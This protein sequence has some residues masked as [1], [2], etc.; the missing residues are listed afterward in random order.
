MRIFPHQDTPPI[1]WTIAGSDPCGGAGL[2]ADIKTL[3]ILGAHACAIVSALTAQ[4]SVGV[5]GTETVSAAML[6]AQIEALRSDMP[7]RAIKIGMLGDAESIR[8]LAHCLAPLDVYTICDPVLVSSSGTPLIAEDAIA[9]MKEFLFPRVNLLT[10][11]KAE[12]EALTRRALL[13]DVDV[14][15]AA[16]DL[17]S[18]GVKAV[19]IK[20]WDSGQ[21]FSQ[22]FYTNA[23]DK[24]WLTSPKRAGV[25]SR[26][27][28]CA[29]SSVLAAAHAF[30]YSEADASVIA[31]IYI[32]QGLRY[33]RRIGKG[34]PLL[35]HDM[36]ACL[37]QDMPWSTRTAP[38]GRTRMVFP[39]CGTE[40]LG[41]YPIVDSAV[42]LERLL[43][44][45]IKT[46]QLRIKSLTGAA[47]EN[48]IKK[49]ISLACHHNCRLFI[50]DYW[51]LALAHN[52]YGVHLGQE[53][54]PIADARALLAL[55]NERSVILIANER[56]SESV[57]AAFLDLFSASFNFKK[58]SV[59]LPSV[60]LR[61][62][63]L[64]L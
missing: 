47:L 17:L 19:L 5:S 29:F 38:Q 10:P 7:A 32:N 62:V 57:Q 6:K 60:G 49:S 11:N 18:F 43:P 13:S 51:E 40:A 3:T 30:G 59:D 31:K 16:Q 41:F 28:G 64:Q 4:N 9:K 52:A 39:D 26:G 56:R 46:A 61:S 2:Q 14:E 48:E 54:M 58:V 44:L 24:F 12:A 45:G 1:V 50:N 63:D 35:A 27:T 20:G 42:W 22:D 33:S 34:M 37:P 23:T 25:T 53:D 36:P 55:T 8:V 15:A 21:G